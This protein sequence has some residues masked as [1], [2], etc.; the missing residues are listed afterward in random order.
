MS[1]HQLLSRLLDYV[2]EQAKDID[3]R[4][5][6][7]SGHKGFKKTKTD[8]QGLPGVDFDIKVEGDH[9]WLRVA[10]LEA[11][12]PPVLPD[13]KLKGLIVVDSEPTGQLPHIDEAA[14]NHRLAAASADRTADQL[15]T[16]E[17]R[18]RADLQRA[19]ADYTP[20]WA[21]WAGGEKPRRRTIGLYGDLFAIKHQLDSEETAKP[22]EL[23]GAVRVE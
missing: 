8:L 20:L 16:D 19:L 17:S 21:A 11:F 6:N 15:R 7:L 12:A 22:H 4:G 18:A 9:T 2:L 13:E 10:R 3:P 23:V 1:A 14:F 5:F